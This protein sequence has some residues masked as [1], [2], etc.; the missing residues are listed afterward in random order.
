MMKVRLITFQTAA[1]MD[2]GTKSKKNAIMEAICT[3]DFKL[4]LTFYEGNALA[5]I[6]LF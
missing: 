4:N 3:I 5:G 2:S 6:I 1:M